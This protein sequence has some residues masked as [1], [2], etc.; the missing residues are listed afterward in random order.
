VK[1]YGE[2][3]ERTKE[4]LTRC[5]GAEPGAVG[6]FCAD[7]HVGYSM[8]IG[9][10]VGYRRFVSP[11]GVGYD[12]ACGNLAVQTNLRAGD[13]PDAEMIRIADEIQRR[14]SFGVGRKNSEP[15]DSPVFDRIASSPVGPQ[16]ALLQMAQAQL[17]TS[18]RAASGTR[19]RPVHEHRAGPYVPRRQ[20]RR[21]HGLSAAAARRVAAEAART[22]WRR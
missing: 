5:I 15:I 21:S 20:G 3:D 9:G 19:R 17:G 11:S 10:V 2:H 18:A 14:I 7:G 12:I 4:Q 13:V 1:I 16:R 22:T 6:V 8:P